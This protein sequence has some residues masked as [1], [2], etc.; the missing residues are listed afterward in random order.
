M[1]VIVFRLCCV[2][3]LFDPF[4][5]PEVISSRMRYFPAKSVLSGAKTYF[6]QI[7]FDYPVRSAKCGP[8]EERGQPTNGANRRTGPTEEHDVYQEEGADTCAGNR[9][10]VNPP[11]KDPCHSCKSPVQSSAVL[12]KSTGGQAVVHRLLQRGISCS[13]PASSRHSALWTADCIV[14]D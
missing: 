11:F 3:A 4:L 12:R 5:L 9:K 7:D 8:T 6:R 10:A 2:C 1:F 14:Y 13:M